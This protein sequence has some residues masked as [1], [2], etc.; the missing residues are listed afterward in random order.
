MSRPRRRT[1]R[2]AS[3]LA[4]KAY[5]NYVRTSKPSREDRFSDNAVALLSGFCVALL[6]I[7]TTVLLATILRV[8]LVICFLLYKGLKAS[9]SKELLQKITLL[10]L[11]QTRGVSVCNAFEIHCEELRGYLDDQV[12]IW[13][14][15]GCPVWR[16]RLRK[17]CFSAE[18]AFGILLVVLRSLLSSK[19]IL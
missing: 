9:S 6:I 13:E 11:G 15:E 12:T 8:V 18:A 17:A 14:A 3:K 2:I 19:R 7:P 5:R 16:I 4:G 1:G 10:C